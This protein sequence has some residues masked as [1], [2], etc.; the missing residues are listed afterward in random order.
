MKVYKRVYKLSSTYSRLQLCIQVIAKLHTKHSHQTFTQEALQIGIGPTRRTIL[1]TVDCLY[2]HQ[3][4][5]ILSNWLNKHFNNC[6]QSDI[7]CGVFNGLNLLILCNSH[8]SVCDIK[9]LVLPKLVEALVLSG[10][11]G[12]YHFILLNLTFIE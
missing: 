12:L 2:S 6:K 9:D 10:Y 4:H 3:P 1:D 5:N 8:V 7:S 11:N